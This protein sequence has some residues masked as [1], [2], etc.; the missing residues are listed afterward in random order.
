MPSASALLWLTPSSADGRHN[1]QPSLCGSTRNSWRELRSQTSPPETKNA[2]AAQLKL[3]WDLK[4]TRIANKLEWF[5]SASIDWSQLNSSPTTLRFMRE[6]NNTVV[7]PTVSQ[8]TSVN[9][10]LSPETIINF[11]FGIEGRHFVPTQPQAWFPAGRDPSH[12]GTAPTDARLRAIQTQSGAKADRPEKPDWLGWTH[13]A[14]REDSSGLSVDFCFLKIQYQT[15]AEIG[16][17]NNEQINNVFE[18]K[19]QLELKQILL[20]RLVFSHASPKPLRFHQ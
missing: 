9:K 20:Y 4:M 14:T 19:I 15:D 11:E 6:N 10:W 12:W 8:Q 7:E 18:A 2:G 17:I 3:K 5:Q 16:H 13:G 1:Q